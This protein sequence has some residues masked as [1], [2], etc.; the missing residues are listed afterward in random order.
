MD[1]ILAGLGF[2]DPLIQKAILSGLL[3]ALTLLFLILIRKIVLRLSLTDER[4]QILARLLRSIIYLVIIFLLLRIWLWTYLYEFF[5]PVVL[6]KLLTSLIGAVVFGLAVYVIRRLISAQYLEQGRK[7]RLMRWGTYAPIILYVFILLRIWA[8]TEQFR[9]LQDPFMKKIYASLFILVIIYALLFLVRRLIN[10]MKIDLKSKY[11]YRK[12]TTYS[13]ALI[14][15]MLLIPIWAGST[16][17]WATI[18]SVMGAGIALALHEVLLNFAGWVYIVVRRPYQ[19]GDRIELGQ[20]K[21]D[22][23]D[24]RI[25]QTILLEIGNWVDGDQSTGRVVQVPHGQI[26]RVPLYNYTKGFEYIWHEFPIMITFESDWK[27]AEQMLLRSGEKVSKELQ[28]QA[29]NKINRMAREY[30]IYYKTLT[31]FVYISVQ[32]SGVKLT[33]R[34]LTDAKKRRS[35][36]DTI[37]REVLKAIAATKDVEFAYPTYRIYRHGEAGS[38][39]NK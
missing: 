22:V 9:L 6:G 36:H 37:S 4:R 17:Q 34:Y 29:R 10:S 28:D 8:F 19:T 15:F 18:F 23:I 31:P 39:E 27:K 20:V 13:G 7:E 24:I 35:G 12:R 14:Y 30:L 3:A 1:T 16:N 32:D 11:Q 33:L 38:E 2:N 21:G 26:F 25:F 5:N